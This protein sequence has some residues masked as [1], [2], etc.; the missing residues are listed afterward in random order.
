M[1]NASEGKKTEIYERF[2]IS[3]IGKY[4]QPDS[5]TLLTLQLPLPWFTTIPLYLIQ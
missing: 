4:D 1:G 2:F 3:E 5:R